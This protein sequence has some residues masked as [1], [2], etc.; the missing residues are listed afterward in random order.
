MKGNIIITHTTGQSD[1]RT[2]RITVGDEASQIEFLEVRLTLE[3]FGTLLTGGREVDCEF[4]L[5]G[6]EKVGMISQNKEEIVPVPKEVRYS[7]DREGA[8][9]AKL[10]APFEVDGWKARKGDLFNHHRQ[11]EDGYRVVFFR[12]VPAV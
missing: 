10:L 4:K 1:N 7:T 3:E 9:S 12:H 2:V 5:K 11:T 8:L 6:A